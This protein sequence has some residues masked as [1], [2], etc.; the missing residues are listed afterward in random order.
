MAHAPTFN[1]KLFTLLQIVPMSAWSVPGLGTRG[2]V[3]MASAE[4][5]A[6]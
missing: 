3:P 2:G 6:S 1:G 5:N 4:E